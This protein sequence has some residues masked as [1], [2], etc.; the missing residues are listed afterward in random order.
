MDRPVTT[1][2]CSPAV[3]SG[4]DAGLAEVLAGRWRAYTR[5]GGRL[6]AIPVEHE[7]WALR[8][9]ELVHLDET[10]LA[11]A[12]LAQPT[13]EPVVHYSDGVEA[14]LGAPRPVTAR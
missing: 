9:A 6:L 13:A 7:P 8:R 5:V 12:D 11:A 4:A 2:W 10:L 1:S 14:R 3:R